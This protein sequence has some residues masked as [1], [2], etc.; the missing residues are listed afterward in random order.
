MGGSMNYPDDCQG[1]IQAPWNEP[2]APECECGSPM[3]LKDNELICDGECD[4]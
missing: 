3:T 2:E 4:E 1:N